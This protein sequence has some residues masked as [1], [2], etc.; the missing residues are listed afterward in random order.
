MLNPSF[1]KQNSTIFRWT[2]LVFALLT[3]SL[4][5]GAS[6]RKQR[7]Y[8]AYISGNRALWVQ[9]VQEMERS[10]EPKTLAWRLELAEYYYG[11]SGYYISAKK[12]DLAAATIEKG[13]ALVNKILREYPDNA[14]ALSYKSALTAFKI[15]LNRLKVLILGRE[16][17]KWLDKASAADPDNIQVLIDRGNALIHAPVIFGGDPEKGV[18]LYK[19]GLALMEKRNLAAGNWFYLQVLIATADAYKRMG[20]TEKARPVY[21]HALEVEPRFRM[22]KEFL[23]PA[24]DKK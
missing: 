1:V 7:I 22:V 13:E 9:V 20:H 11:L 16:S 17:L 14:T 3:C 6:T 19:R 23:L 8:E 15:N 5:Q 18:Q 2:L 4:S 10:T 24:L 12:N 21:L